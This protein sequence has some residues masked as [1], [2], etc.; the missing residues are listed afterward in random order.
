MPEELVRLIAQALELSRISGGF[1]RRTEDSADDGLMLLR[2]TGD[3]C[4][5]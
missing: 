3:K 1:N 4:V 5:A 2:K